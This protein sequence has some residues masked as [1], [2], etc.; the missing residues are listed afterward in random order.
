MSERADTPPGVAAN[1]AHLGK[2]YRIYALVILT[3]VYVLNYVDRQ[4]LAILLPGIK[5]ELDLNDTQLGF[6]FMTFGIFY[7]TLGIPIAMLAD[8]TNRR[9]VVAVALTI[10]SLMTAACAFV[11]NY[12]QLVI[13]RVL[14]GVGEAGSSPP[15]HSMIADMFPPKARA[16]ALAFFS[17][18]VNIGLLIG[19]FAGG[20]L[21][22]NY[23]WRTTFIIVG[24]PG[25]L[26]ALVVLFT[27]KEPER[28]ASDGVAP[29][30]E[31]TPAIG[32]VVSFLWSQKAFRHI[33]LGSA[34]I[35]FV[36]YAGVAWVPTFLA[37]SFDMKLGEIGMMLG[38]VIGF[39]GGAGTFGAGFFADKL[40]HKDVR[41][42]MW[43]VALAGV[44]AFPFGVALYLTDS[45]TA[46]ILL[47]IAPAAAGAI[48]TGPAIA[49][50]Q[51]LAKLR[52]RATASAILFFILNLI[53]LGAGPQVVGMLS[54]FFAASAGEESVRYALLAIT[55]LGLWGALHF[56]L[57]AKT[58]EED[59]ARAKA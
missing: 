26:M 36:G 47:F 37:R 6:L 35:A 20:W 48:F 3:I 12:I 29:G 56:F 21:A 54:D 16:T 52:M 57:A 18:G 19:L 2:G 33:A 32:E 27:V 44:V 1:I 45:K 4:I 49:M 53:G 15:S 38:L 23:G 46:A 31:E 17:L 9:N 34:L 7:A 22:E 5:A 10:F 51:G 25:V 30:T 39:A 24:L 28:G 43:L 40:G 42:N 55:P 8:R 50:T 11:A 59:L 14:V 13:L 58:L 41:W